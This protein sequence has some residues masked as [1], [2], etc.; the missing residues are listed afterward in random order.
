MGQAVAPSQTSASESLQVGKVLSHAICDSKGELLLPPGQVITAEFLRWLKNSHFSE[1]YLLEPRAAGKATLGTRADPKAVLPYDSLV[2]QRL[3]V[4]YEDMIVSISDFANRLLDGQRTRIDE[5]QESVQNYLIQLRV[6][7]AVVLASCTRSDASLSQSRDATLAHRSLLLSVL[8]IAVATQL[9]LNEADCLTVGIAG[10]I[11]DVSLFGE[12][13]GTSKQRYRD[14]PR[15]SCELLLNS[16]GIT[17]ELNI[18]VGQVHEQCDG[19]GFPG[20][21]THHRLHPLS[22]LLNVIDAYLT[23]TEPHGEDGKSFT[24]ADAVAYLVQQALYGYFDR[25]CVRALVKTASVYPVGTLVQLSDG[26]TATVL[27]STGESYLE[28]V[29]QLCDNA[30]TIIDLRFSDKIII[31][32]MGNPDRYRRLS[33]PALDQVLWS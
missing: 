6:D 27:R 1:V 16:Y 3:D 12:A 19:S 32:P 13:P 7:A 4:Y 23:L 11:H 2:M 14:H 24:P 22:R 28:P 21:L 26:S 9:K 10:A 8:A 33:K 5:F 20:N 17:P 18:I 25:E 29:V 31:A 30:G 15:R